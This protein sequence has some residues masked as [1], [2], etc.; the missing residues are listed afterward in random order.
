MSRT[1]NKLLPYHGFEGDHLMSHDGDLIAF[2]KVSLWPKDAASKADKA[3]IA[4]ALLIV[5]DALPAGFQVQQY[6]IKHKAPAIQMPSFD[7]PAINE[8]VKAHEDKTNSSP[9]YVTH[10]YWAISLKTD[11]VFAAPVKDLLSLIFKFLVGRV[12]FSDLKSQ[13]SEL[14]QSLISEQLLHRSMLELVNA[15]EQL[16]S[17]LLTNSDSFVFDGLSQKEVAG[18]LAFMVSMDPIY[19]INGID[20]DDDLSHSLPVPNIDQVI[21]DDVPAI[22]LNTDLPVYITPASIYRFVKSVKTDFWSMSDSDS[23]IMAYPGEFVVCSGFKPFS[24]V[25]KSLKFH[26]HKMIAENIHFNVISQALKKKKKTMKSLKKSNPVIYKRFKKLQN[27]R[28]IEIT[29]GDSYFTLIPFSSN[30][31]ELKKTRSKLA[32]FVTYGSARMAFE[33]IGRMLAYQ[34]VMPGCMN[35]SA[36]LM[37][38]NAHQYAALSFSI[39]QHKGFER[40][41]LVDHPYPLMYLE[42]VTSELFGLSPYPNQKTLVLAVGETRSGKT[43]F[44]NKFAAMMRQLGSKI[45]TVDIDDG[46][47]PLARHFSDDSRIFEFP[48]FKYNPYDDYVAGVNDDVFI[49]HIVSLCHLI[50]SEPLTNREV[51]V[52][53]NAVHAQLGYGSN[54]HTI[55]HFFGMIPSELANKFA[56][57]ITGIHKDFF[58]SES[59]KLSTINCFNLKKVFKIPTISDLSFYTL[60]FKINNEFECKTEKHVP[61]YLLIDE[62]HEALRNLAVCRQVDLISRTGNKMMYGIGLFT[63]SPHELVKLEY[64]PA[65]KSSVCTMMF[66]SDPQMDRDLYRR[67]FTLSEHEL[68]QIGSLKRQKELYLIQREAG[69]SVKLQFNPSDYYKKNFTSNPQEIYQNQKVAV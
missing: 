44:K 41:E 1:I 59:E 8:L 58:S 16:K 56:K 38:M 34:S 48:D 7:D 19:L 18:F 69:I 64:W 32:G 4:N 40:I 65:L 13:V 26:K 36:R 37:T 63:Q 54:L 52:I 23:D 20:F 42:T 45:A 14:D 60:L 24:S 31:D 53:E 47:Y 27:A 30:L 21:A 25:K 28:D 6:L 17:I 67:T 9:H 3:D 66:F 51:E 62:A 10:T 35:L 61:K 55:N 43:F 68:D 39:S 29:Y 57:F 2:F 50:A 11:A 12:K 5:F 33:S 15:I 46:S 22:R 49:Q